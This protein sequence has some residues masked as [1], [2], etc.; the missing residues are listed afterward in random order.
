MES[1]F[2]VPRRAVGAFEQT[3]GLKVG[4]HDFRGRLVPFLPPDCLYHTSR[5]CFATKSH[6]D[7]ACV[8]FDVK[9]LRSQIPTR[10][11]G[12]IKL[13]HAGLVEWVVPSFDADGIEWVLFAGQRVAGKS[14]SGVLYD[15]QPATRPRPWADC[16]PSPAPVEDDEAQRLLELLRQLVSRLREWRAGIEESATLPR[17]QAR[18][19]ANAR[20]A[21]IHRFIQTRHH[22]AIRLTDLA[23]F[24]G[25]SESR[26]G[27]AVR[28]SCGAS[29]VELLNTARMQTAQSLLEYTNLSVLEVATR[30]GFGDLS[31]FHSVF[32]RAH[33]QTPLQYRKRRQTG[34][35]V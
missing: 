22:R 5:Y 7:A 28:E 23:K 15:P 31:H 24:M 4:L 19:E 26:A 34:V 30:S 10:P 16:R 21:A 33:R 32:R 20:P 9:H 25:L 3:T 29:F 27:H 1:L 6:N 17:G 13:C 12:L 35:K 11:E 18:P 8:L 2:E 14:L